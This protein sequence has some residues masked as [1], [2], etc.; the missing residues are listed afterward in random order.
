MVELIYEI[1]KKR[2]VALERKIKR[3]PVSNFRASDIHECD[4]CDKYM[5]CAILD[6]EKRSLHDVALQAIFDAGNKEEE[7]VKNRLGYELGI[8]SIEQ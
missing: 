8:E 3:L 6:W 5:V 4:E 7:N 1:V 2:R